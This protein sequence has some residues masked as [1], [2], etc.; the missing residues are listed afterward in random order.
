MNDL[1]VVVPRSE[2]ARDKERNLSPACHSI[3]NAE[4]QHSEALIYVFGASGMSRS[5][6]YEPQTRLD[7][8][9]SLKMHLLSLTLLISTLI[10][11]FLAVSL[12]IHVCRCWPYSSL[13]KKQETRAT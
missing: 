2:T 10:Y 7:V 12:L 9:K 4:K 11:F 3:K 5:I 13:G 6:E 8:E 1:Q